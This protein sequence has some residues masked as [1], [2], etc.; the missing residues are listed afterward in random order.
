MKESLLGENGCF[1]GCL[2]DEVEWEL[3]R[4]IDMRMSGKA[5]QLKVQTSRD[6]GTSNPQ[7]PQFQLPLFS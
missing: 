2:E 4:I 1:A 3:Q 6:P 7:H 5:T